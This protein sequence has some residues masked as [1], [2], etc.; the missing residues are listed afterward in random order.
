MNSKLKLFLASVALTLASCGSV[1]QTSFASSSTEEEMSSI[2]SSINSTVESLSSEESE[3]S[4]SQSSEEETLSTSIISLEETSS[5]EEGVDYMDYVRAIKPNPIARRVK[6][7]DLR[8]NSDQR[9]LGGKLPPK[10][11]LYLE[12]LAYLETED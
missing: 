3:I 6:I 8:H 2:V 11:A 10:Y 4:L 1:P 5:D 12:A 9:R 7:A